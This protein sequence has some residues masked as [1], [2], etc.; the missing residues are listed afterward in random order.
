MSNEIKIA[1]E[2]QKSEYTE[3][4]NPSD[5]KFSSRKVGPLISTNRLGIIMNILLQPFLYKIKSCVRDNIHF[6]NTIQ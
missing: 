6:L 1:V 5:I 3:I 4:P 2:T